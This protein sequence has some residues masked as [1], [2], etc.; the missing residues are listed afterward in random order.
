MLPFAL[1]VSW[2]ISDTSSLQCV[3]NEH[4]TW[5]GSLRTA[6]AI[7]CKLATRTFPCQVWTQMLP[8]STKTVKKK[9]L[10]K[11]QSLWRHLHWHDKDKQRFR[12]KRITRGKVTTYTIKT[13]RCWM[14][15]TSRWKNMMEKSPNAEIRK[16][17]WQ[18]LWLL[19]S[20]NRGRLFRRKTTY[21]DG[22][23]ALKTKR[24]NKRTMY[25]K[26]IAKTCL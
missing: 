24:K 8:F 2:P 12:C 13:G 25:E 3:T 15:C 9:E 19:V 17:T 11:G 6:T 23:Y 1:R 26:V 16:D 10:T 7:V 21:C 5:C 4:A 20:S 18:T 14:K 22:C